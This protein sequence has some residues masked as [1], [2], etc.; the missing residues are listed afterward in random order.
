MPKVLLHICCAGCAAGAIARLKEEGFE[1]SGF[2]YNPNIHPLSEYQKRRQSL[3]VISRYYS[4]AIQ[5]G[6][7]NVQRWFKE[8]RGYEKEPEGGKRCAICFRLRLEKTYQLF[9]QEQKYDFFT[10][11]LTIGPQKKSQIINQI[12]T[13]I[14]SYFLVRDFKK[15]DGFKHAVVISKQLGIYRQNYC[16]CIFSKQERQKRFKS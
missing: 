7:Y 14:S 12:G 10:T 2:F 9:C 4:V 6:E 16:G 15:K 13:S 8:I 1:V 3:D 5:E 11:T